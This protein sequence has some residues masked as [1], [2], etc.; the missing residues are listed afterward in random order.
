MAG[1]IISEIGFGIHA[2]HDGYG[3]LRVLAVS[4]FFFAG[5]I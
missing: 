2:D 1:Y 3:F 5:S 4:L